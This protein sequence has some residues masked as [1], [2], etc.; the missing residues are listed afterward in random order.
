MTTTFGGRQRFD[1][2]RV[3]ERTFG[4]IGDNAA[5]L[6]LSALLFVGLPQALWGLVSANWVTEYGW[7]IAFLGGVGGWIVTMACSVLL[8]GVVTHTVVA[9]LLGKKASMGESVSA[10]LRS[11]WLLLGVGVLGGLAI[12][13]GTL[14]LIVPGVFLML[15]WFVAGPVAVAERGM[16][17]GEVFERSQKL[18]ENHRWTLLL[19]GVIYVVAAW[20]IMLMIGMI[21][22]VASGGDMTQMNAIVVVVTAVAQALTSLIAAAGVA[23]VYVELRTV[24]EGAAHQ[25]VAAI[26]E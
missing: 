8:Q 24:K 26:F 21:A 23:A 6:L 16:S 11:F 25:S 15:I 20:V 17:L 3:I 12:A 9:D 10:A 19:L 18:T 2:G 1:L 5:T 7:G 4:S 13:L 14:L 22:G